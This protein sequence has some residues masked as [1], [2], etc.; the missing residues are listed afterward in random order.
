MVNYILA[1]YYG[2]LAY[3]RS[4]SMGSI[5]IRDRND[6]RIS[7]HSIRHRHWSQE[8]WVGSNSTH[9]HRFNC[10]GQHSGGWPI[11]G[12]LH[13]PSSGLRT[14]PG[15]LVLGWPLDLLGWPTHRRR[16]SRHC[17]WALLHWIHPPALARCR[18][19]KKAIIVLCVV[20][21]NHLYSI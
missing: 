2:I 1:G 17:V 4:G 7:L 13:E 14:C 19:L 8:R 9:C 16:L 10:G 6:I 20:L 5:C 18:V 3:S 15:V 12:S 11:H 21:I